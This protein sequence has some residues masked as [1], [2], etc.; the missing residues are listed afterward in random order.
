MAVRGTL[1]SIAGFDPSSGAGITADLQVFGAHEFFGISAITAL[2]V[3]STRGVE[4]TQPVDPDWLA[5][6]LSCVSSD[7][8]PAGI[9]IGMLASATNVRVVAGFLRAL[10]GPVP[11]VL[12]PVML[13]TSGRE[14]LTPEGVA[15][16]RDQLLSL[17]TWVTPNRAELAQLTGQTI[18]SRADTELAALRFAKV[19]PSLNLVVTGGEFDPSEDLLVTAGGSCAWLTAEH[20]AS[21][22]TH[23]TG[24]AF[25]S[26]LLCR[27][28][29]ATG[30]QPA[31]AVQ[32]AKDFVRNAILT[33]T[34]LGRGRGPM[35]LRG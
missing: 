3:Q 8:P 4:A 14:L 5:A 2:T 6:T 35:N 24:C 9:K 1:L 22:A 25:S 29:D 7:L 10:P 17:V 26:A 31:D 27:L 18:L 32:L 21:R 34:P 30:R 15:M 28:C 12:D 11:V 23:G 19:Y 20:I 33:A 16:L 13:S